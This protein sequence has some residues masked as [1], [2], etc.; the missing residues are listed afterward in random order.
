MMID[1][2][3]IAFHLLGALALAIYVVAYFLRKGHYPVVRA[4]VDV[5]FALMFGTL[6]AFAPMVIYLFYALY[7]VVP[8]Y[9]LTQ[10]L[11]NCRTVNFL[12]YQVLPAVCAITVGILATKTQ[13]S[14]PFGVV[15]T[16]VFPVIAILLNLAI[17]IFGMM[18]KSWSLAPL[19]RSIIWIVYFIV[20]GIWVSIAYEIFNLVIYLSV[21]KQRGEL[22]TIQWKKREGSARCSRPRRERAYRPAREPKQTSAPVGNNTMSF[23][24]DDKNVAANAYVPAISKGQW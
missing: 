18:G 21:L 5:L 15:I 6:Q 23:D 10:K 3:N 14:S 12:L 9:T 17:G 24:G 11:K 22:P 7:T 13:N 4:V 1:M 20:A 2:T 8:V 19:V 16:F